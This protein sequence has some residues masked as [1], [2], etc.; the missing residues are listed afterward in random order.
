MS[1]YERDDKARTGAIQHQSLS[2][3]IRGFEFGEVCG[4]GAESYI[5]GSHLIPL[6]LSKQGYHVGPIE[7]SRRVCVSYLT[8]IH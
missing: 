8:L 4:L 6:P 5:Q 1:A 2:C 7:D 3:G